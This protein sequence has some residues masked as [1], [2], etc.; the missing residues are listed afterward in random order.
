[1]RKGVTCLGRS[2]CEIFANSLRSEIGAIL[3]QQR[4]LDG[5]ERGNDILVE[6]FAQYDGASAA[7]HGMHGYDAHVR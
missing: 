6:Q 3:G 5:Y 1:M 7:I 2:T 4:G